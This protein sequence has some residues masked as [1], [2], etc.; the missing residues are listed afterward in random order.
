M[1]YDSGSAI[2]LLRTVSDDGADKAEAIVKRLQEAVERRATLSEKGAMLKLE[3]WVYDRLPSGPNS[4][5][6]RFED[7]EKALNI[8]AETAK[9]LLVRIADESSGLL[10]VEMGY[11]VVTVVRHIYIASL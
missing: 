9:R 6:V 2:P 10:E 4:M 11:D 5:L 7:I 3:N 8:A 1:L